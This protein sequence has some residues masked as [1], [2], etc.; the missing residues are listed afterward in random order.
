MNKEIMNKDYLSIKEF[1]DL[2]GMTAAAIRHYGKKEIFQPA[3][4]GIDLENKYRYYAPT[5]IT[6]IKMIRVL[7][8]IGVPLDT[9][10]ALAD[11][12]SPEKLIKL[13]SRQKGIVA[14]E[15]SYLQDVYSI[16]CTFLDLMIEGISAIESEI[17]VTEYSER[18]ILLGNK[19]DFCMTVGFYRE[20]MRFCNTPHDPPLNL[21]Y[22]VGGFFESMDVFLNNPSQPT[23][24][25]SLDPRGKQTREA[26][27]YLIGY[28]R[29]YYGQTNDLPKRMSA[30]ARKNGLVFNGPVYNLYLFDEM[31]I[32]DTEQYL[33][34][35]S[36]SVKETRRVPSRRPMRQN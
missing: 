35:A 6:T 24:F 20:F 16:I 26:G 14:D 27:L 33:L 25:F 12:R 18:K 19:N 29:G 23:R 17:Y 32:A 34:Q 30:F 21:S 9:I 1:A 7:T 4:H 28:T 2:V 8:E 3:K 13:L 10:K 22:P 15:L 5:Q 36:A 31:S 11:D